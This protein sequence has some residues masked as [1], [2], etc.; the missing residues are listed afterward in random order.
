MAETAYSG[1]AGAVESPSSLAQGWATSPSTPPPAM[2]PVARPFVSRPSHAD[3]G[4]S[5]TSRCFDPSAP[6]PVSPGSAASSP[7][8]NGMTAPPSSG[9]P[10]A[11]GGIGLHQMALVID[12]LVFVPQVAIGTPVQIDGLLALDRFQKPGAYIML[13]PADPISP[14]RVRIGE[15]RNVARRLDSKRADWI[16][17]GFS[18]IILITCAHCAFDKTDAEALEARLTAIIEGSRSAEVLRDA[19][20]KLRRLDSARQQAIDGLIDLVRIELT[21]CGIDLLASAATATPYGQPHAALQSVPAQ[22]GP[23]HPAP[24]HPAPLPSASMHPASMAPAHGGIDAGDYI[25]RG[26]A[27]Q[28]AAHGRSAGATAT[29]RGSRQRDVTRSVFHLPMFRSPRPAADPDGALLLL[30]YGELSG[31]LRR[32][33]AGYEIGAGTE[34]GMIEVPCLPETARRWR[35]QLLDSG[36]IGPDPARPGTWIARR[37][38]TLPSLTAA[39][40]VATGSSKSPRRVWRP[41]PA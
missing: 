34:I 35:R 1:A 39:A 36:I 19:A 12:P 2:P 13:K 37:P 25:P 30:H 24:M 17:T 5:A 29:R 6:F 15:G 18:R 41:R 21:R 20:P 28:T 14:A 26:L 16:E 22:P 27:A 10:L 32:V 11:Y 33:G 9:Q 7:H 3:P 4:H 8:F 40:Q 31:H 38:I 23:M